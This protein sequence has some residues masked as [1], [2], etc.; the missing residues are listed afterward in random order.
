MYN[1]QD[2]DAPDGLAQLATARAWLDAPAF[3]RVE[4]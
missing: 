3:V 2:P 4:P 1:H